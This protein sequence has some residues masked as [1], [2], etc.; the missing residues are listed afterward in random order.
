MFTEYQSRLNTGQ[1]CSLPLTESSH[2]SLWEVTA[3]RPHLLETQGLGGVG[4]RNLLWG[5]EP[6]TSPYQK[7]P[8]SKLTLGG[9]FLCKHSAESYR[10]G[11]TH[12]EV[13]PA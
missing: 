11:V 8:K 12:R 9:P 7:G 6:V 4:V 10:P 1:Q 3:I 5:A 13:G 2:V